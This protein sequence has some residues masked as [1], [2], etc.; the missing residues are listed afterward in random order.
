MDN[1][2]YSMLGETYG[3]IGATAHFFHIDGKNIL[4]D[5]GVGQT[6]DE[7]G[8]KIRYLPHG[9]DFLSTQH[10][11]LIINTHP[12][13][14]HIG[15]FPRIVSRHPE[16]RVVIPYH[17]H[18][19]AGIIF[20]DALNIMRRD[21][22]NVF[23]DD[24]DV[25]KFLSHP[26][27]ELIGRNE[28]GWRHSPWPNWEGWKIG[29]HPSGHYIGAL[30]V[31]FISPSGKRIM[32]TGDTSSQDQN[33]VP[34][35]MLPNDDFF[36]GTDFFN[37]EVTLITE[38][39]NAARKM[40]T[41]R[42]EVKKKLIAFV[43][44]IEKKGGTLFFPCFGRQ[45]AAEL[46]LILIEAGYKVHIDGMASSLA[47]IEAPA[48]REAQKQ[49]KVAFFTGRWI[50]A[51]YHRRIACRGQDPCGHE[52]C[53]IIAPSA[54]LEGGHAVGHAKRIF[55]KE[56]NGV[57]FVGHLFENTPAYEISH[58][59]KFSRGHTIALN[60]FGTEIHI[61]IRCEIEHFDLTAHDYQ[62]SLLERVQLVK[63]RRLIVHH[64][65]GFSDYLEFKA[66]VE[67]FPNVPAEIH[68]VS[69]IN[70]LSI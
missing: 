41:T 60:E 45:R 9:D 33:S 65:P 54:S 2:F 19:V 27:L 57:A 3:K 39:T 8:K 35:V 59:R 69:N 49:G 25:A 15:A 11:D 47:P 28:I 32:L 70:R 56:E 55:P 4:V 37:K 13:D 17:A 53:I 5:Y 38:G 44:K 22:E 48:L 36:H 42:D 66:E 14:D 50:V 43:E 6:R 31:Y 67:R 52:P 64:C 20:R 63:P 68:Y 61:D 30:S 16:A 58:I 51:E 1:S 10:I 34:G 21:K 7:E 62:E 23:F 24:S 29:F 12:H 46:A 40:K 26:H 18:K